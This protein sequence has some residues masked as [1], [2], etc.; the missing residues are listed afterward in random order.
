MKR[1]LLIGLCWLVGSCWAESASFSV[2]G[3]L[4]NGA[5]TLSPEDSEID[6][7]MRRWSPGS[8]EVGT[9]GSAVPF[10]IHLTD[11][12]PTVAATVTATFSGTPDA[13]NPAIL[14]L[15]SSS[16]AS[17]VAIALSDQN[18]RDIP[19]TA[20]TYIWRLVAGANDIPLQAQVEVV[21]QPVV[22]GNFSA[23]LN[24]ELSYP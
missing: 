21:R 24:F 15:D 3:T 5:C 19:L 14:A 16:V 7:N 13:H 6:V 10:V 20:P 23:T 4:V 8:A 2:Y 18:S 12:D 1:Y 11:C 9:R 17:G 22:P